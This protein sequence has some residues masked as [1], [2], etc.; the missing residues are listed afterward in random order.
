[1]KP[2]GVAMTALG[3]SRHFAELR[4][5]GRERRIA[6]VEARPSIA[7]GGA[8][9]PSAAQEKASRMHVFRASERPSFPRG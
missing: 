9:D 1:M 4:D 6:E 5:L 8:R 3:P 2:N 7:D